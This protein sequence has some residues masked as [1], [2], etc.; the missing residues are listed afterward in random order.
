MV[1]GFTPPG[2]HEVLVFLV[3]V[4]VLVGLARLGGGLARRLGQPAVVGELVAGVVAGPSI[5]G[6]VAAGAFDWTFGPDQSAAMVSALAWLGLLLLLATTGVES[7][8]AVVRRL[9]RSAALVTTG[10][11]AVPLAGGFLLGLLTPAGLRGPTTQVVLFAAF[12][13]VAMSIS[14][15]PVV[16]RVLSEL[17]MVRR[18]VGQLV[19]AVAVANDVIGW[20]LLGLVVGV[21]GS[22][23][24]PGPGTVL[25]TVIAVSIFGVAALTA[26]RFAVEWALRQAAGSGLDT[27]VGLTVGIVV[28]ASAITHAI[29][30]E[31][32]LGAF[33]AGLVIGRSRWRDDR[34]VSVLQS[35]TNGVLAPLFFATAGLRVDLFV[36][37]DPIIAV[38]SLIILGVAT[39]T[40]LAG[41][42]AGA[43]FAGLAGPEARALGIGLNA[44]GALEI[45]IASIGLSIGILT[46]ASY[47]AIVIMAIATSIAAPPLLRRTLRD[48]PGSDAEQRRLAAEDA[49][50]RRVILSARPPLLLTR[51]GDASIA[52]AQFV[53]FCW[54]A[55]H[56]V[57]VATSLER[58]RLTPITSTFADRHV[59]VVVTGPN[60]DRLA[61]EIRRGYSAIAMGV[62]ESPGAPPLG[63]LHRHVLA[64]ANTPVIVVRRE[65]ITG[66]RLPAAFTHALVPITES[67]TSRAALE[68]ATGM[69]IAL[70]TRLT[71]AHIVTE[72]K[73]L[74]GATTA[75]MIETAAPALR[76]AA[77]TARLAGA[78]HVTTVA[79]TADNAAAELHRLA[80][81]LDSD[82]IVAGTTIHED[83]VG[84]TASF[85][86][87]HAP[88]TVAIIATPPGWTR[89]PT[90]H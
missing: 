40:K 63:P 58:N 85:L 62:N 19:L 90:S 26:G 18:D 34:A 50:R 46:D 83:R 35:V 70:G 72:P 27:Q 33:V 57:A 21:A 76:A 53:D 42:L 60:P 13:A 89:P 43:H 3:Q 55:H 16:A 84:P 45:V 79:R 24:A 23:T 36:F 75:T 6:R 4:S 20:L 73:V 82:I 28:V 9:G 25:A 39:V 38:W 37:G 41:V 12:I 31:A 81:E 49:A 87:N 8:L 10:S 30:V 2:D 48:W 7:D 67:H 56:P 78:H 77:E 47:A 71:L 5:F 44:R 69:A 17:G 1:V 14:S 80:L 51:A 61:T 74:A 54:P 66:N 64:H 32:V 59:E 86:L 65:R 11:L 29:G 88:A 68:L 52:A 22:G 15:L